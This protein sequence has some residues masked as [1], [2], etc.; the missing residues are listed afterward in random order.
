[1]AAELGVSSKTVSGLLRVCRAVVPLDS[2]CQIPQEIQQI[3][4][5]E[6]AGAEAAKIE[7]VPESGVIEP[8]QQ[9][10]NVTSFHL[11]A[12]SS[13]PEPPYLSAC[14]TQKSTEG[15]EGEKKTQSNSSKSA[16]SS[17]SVN[18]HVPSTASPSMSHCSEP[19]AHNPNILSSNNKHFLLSVANHSLRVSNGA[20]A[21]MN[22][23]GHLC[24]D[25]FDV[26]RI[27]AV[28][29]ARAFTLLSLATQGLISREPEFKRDRSDDV[30]FWPGTDS[31]SV[32]AQ[33]RVGTPLPLRDALKLPSHSSASEKVEPGNQ[34][35]SPLP[36]ENQSRRSSISAFFGGNSS[37]SIAQPSSSPA[38][39]WEDAILLSID[40]EVVP[41]PIAVRITTF[42]CSL[43]L[44][45][46]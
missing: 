16:A 42:P 13:T 10:T 35:N 24:S 40:G 32:S 14:S 31:V 5:L 22:P 30:W 26:V 1:M 23:T 33:S 37:S 15:K 43:R 41:K 27:C 29:R 11:E 4:H 3:L 25:G 46:L 7:R 28:S 18:S 34:G 6:T 9:S 36:S 20:G 39:C 21:A 38:P 2:N 12:L 45:A 44:L 17:K 19:E 8:S